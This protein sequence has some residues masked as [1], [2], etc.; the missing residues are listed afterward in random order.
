MEVDQPDWQTAMKTVTQKENFISTLNSDNAKHNLD[1]NH[2]NNIKKKVKKD[3][4]DYDI[5]RSD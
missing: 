4:E 1:N 3:L 2:L 5:A